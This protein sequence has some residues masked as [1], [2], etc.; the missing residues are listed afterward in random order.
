MFASGESGRSI[1]IKSDTVCKIGCRLSHLTPYPE[2]KHLNCNLKLFPQASPHH[3]IA[4]AA[5]ALVATISSSIS[6][7][8]STA[9][10]CR[11]LPGP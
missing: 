2:K 11:R 8:S 5:Y 3:S 10:A 9:C 7:N 1:S 4:A 6:T